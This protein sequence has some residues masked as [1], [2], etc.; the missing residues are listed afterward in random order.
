M[1]YD[2]LVTA[3]TG[4]GT[5][6]AAIESALAALAVETPS[7]GYGDS[8]TRFGTFPQ[9]GRPR[10]AFERIDDAAEVHRLTGTA[11][12]VAL[13]FPWDAVDDLDALR[14]PRRRGQPEPLPGARL[15]AWLRDPPRRRGP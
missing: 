8:G 11:P 13:H 6:V 15:Q 3:L 7:W 1:S 5:D 12:G 9:P 10:D 14:A 2:A 4:R